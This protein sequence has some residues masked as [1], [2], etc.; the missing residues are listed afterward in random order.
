[1]CLATL[2]VNRRHCYLL[3]ALALLIASYDIRDF[4]WQGSQSLHTLMETIAT[5]LAFLVGILALI[6]YFSQQDS[7]FLYIGAGFLGT[8]LL[9]AYHTVVT[10]AFFLPFMPSNYPHLVPW[11]WLASRL[12]LSVML[13]ISWWLWHRHRHKPDYQHKTAAV[14]WGTGLATLSCFLFFALF[15]LPSASE[16]E[17]TI[18]RP[19]D[20]IPAVFF[21]AALIGYLRKG[22]W[23]ENDFDHWLVLSLIVGFATQSTFMPL[24]MQV[25]DTEFNVSHLL[26]KLSYIL[27]MVGLLINLY[28][29]YLALRQ[30][31][32][33]RMAAE[34]QIRESE[35]K[36]NTILENVD[37]CIYLKDLN[38]RYLYANRKT[39]DLFQQELEQI[40]G[41]D[42]ERF[43][44]AD[45]VRQIHNNDRRVLDHGETLRCEEV[46]TDLKTGQTINYLT[47]KLPL[48]Q[49]D[50]SIYAL[51]GI[52][53]DISELKQVEEQLRQYKDRLEDK[54]RQRTAELLQ[55][56]AL[57]ADTQ[58]AMDKAGIGIHWIDVE[59]GRFLYVNDYAADLLGYAPTEM[60]QLNI[61]DVDPSLTPENFKERMQKYAAIGTATIETTERHKD[62]H[63]IPISLT[64]YYQAHAVDRNARFISFVSDITIRKQAEAQLIEAKNA[65][66]AA[67][68]SKTVFL[69]NISHELRTPLNAILGFTQL[70]ERDNRIPEDQKRK[71]TTINRAGNHLL[72]LINDVLEISRIEAGR[73]ATVKEPFDLFEM[74]TV[75]EE[76]IRVRASTKGLAFFTEYA[77]D[78]PN[79]VRGDAHHLRQVLLNLLGNA[80][81]YTE[82]GEIRLAVTPTADKI[83]FEVS[84]TG[85]GID[86]AESERIFQPFYQTKFGAAQGEGTGLG[87]TISRNFVRLMEGELKLESTL[88][89]GS[90]FSFSI[91]LA[92]APSANSSSRKRITGLM[93]GQP[94]PRIL[95]VEDH[96]DNQQIVKEMLEQIG[97]KVI[98]ANNGLQALELFQSEQPQLILMDMRMPEMDGYQATRT[99]RHLPGGDQLPI[100]ALTASAFEED[101]SAVIAAGCTEMLRKPV[102]AERLYE[103]IGQMLGLRYE[104]TTFD[105]PNPASISGDLSALPDASKAVLHEAATMLDVETTQAIIDGLHP[106]FPAEAKLLE[107]LMENYAFD[108]IIK[109]LQEAK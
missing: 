27:V 26:K 83:R 80:V 13:F 23:A 101:R 107:R 86:V 25:N 33:R 102:E 96:L 77:A 37:A 61:T 56:N 78:L 45:T 31:T 29:S 71:I 55:S 48:R 63:N 104:Y 19:F 98:I 49:S 3:C 106:A 109:L 35:T 54:V 5:L 9:D 66:E 46:D 59:S 68:R 40:I 97:C 81:K 103:T 6:R 64:F 4:D 44:D 69:S 43:F 21:L 39:L 105:A 28:Q 91:P 62:G 1:M 42:D 51:C 24:S 82:H 75:V 38:G 32:E 15:P 72:A 22:L 36:L 52:S 88:G 10:S 8:G 87:L 95:L 65:A 90:C 16:P 7:Q 99:I 57:L 79:F 34:K 84:D 53:T 93:P 89:K 12:F 50:G 67:S 30:E 14:F 100:V 73:T 58:F 60:Q 18:P 17:W 11:S 108:K 92:A 76:M 20:F 70:M 47:V 74:L 41:Q 94:I 85:P 2:P